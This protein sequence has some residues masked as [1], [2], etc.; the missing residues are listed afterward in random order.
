MTLI[1]RIEKAMFFDDED[2][3]K[4]SELLLSLYEQA[5]PEEKSK[6]DECLICICGWSLPILIQQE[7]NDA[8][9]NEPLR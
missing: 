4:Q 1:D 3:K 8:E 2:R 7:G 5:T 9:S 6:I